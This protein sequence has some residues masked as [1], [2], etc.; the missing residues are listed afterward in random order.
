MAAIIMEC[1]R[2]RTEFK[3][4]VNRPYNSIDI[5]T[6]NIMAIIITRIIARLTR[7]SISWNI[8]LVISPKRSHFPNNFNLL[9]DR[10]MQ[11]TW[12][13]CGKIT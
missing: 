2:W 12:R 3:M 10:D 1:L 9:G 6:L 11:M 13:Y 5:I 8:V 7:S 4:V